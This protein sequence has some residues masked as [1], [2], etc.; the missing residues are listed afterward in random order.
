[1]Q[2]TEDEDSHSASGPDD[3]LEDPSSGY[4][5]PNGRP[6]SQHEKGRS[7]SSTVHDRSKAVPSFSSQINHQPSASSASLASSR[8]YPASHL[9]SPSSPFAHQSQ[10]QSLYSQTQNRN[11]P[12]SAKESFLNY[13]FGGQDP[14]LSGPASVGA[15]P[16][17]IVGQ[18]QMPASVGQGRE[19][20]LHGRKGLEG[21]AAAYE[22]KSLEKHLEPVRFHIHLPLDFWK[23]RT[24]KR[25]RT[26]YKAPS[27]NQ[28][29]ESGLTQREEM[30]TNLIRALI[31]SYFSIVRQ[32][33][34]DL[35]PKAIMRAFTFPP[36]PPFSLST[37]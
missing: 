13:F 14:H 31:A 22:M 5:V 16:G 7:T 11:D 1:M 28:P 12:H 18:L 24:E 36:F 34:K 17:R 9:T 15:H 21:N 23:M 8:A 19:N 27:L 32:T 20:P 35:V 2:A 33:V 25:M 29:G 26:L 37:S 30:E 6:S 10:S 4:L 3:D